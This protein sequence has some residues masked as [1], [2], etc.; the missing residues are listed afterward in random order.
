MHHKLYIKKYVLHI[1]TESR[2]IF[3][4]SNGSTLCPF[5]GNNEIVINEI[6]A[7]CLVKLSFKSWVFNSEPA[8]H[9]RSGR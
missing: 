8:G 9:M 1:P 6:D 2:L 7:S 3:D 5:W 4:F